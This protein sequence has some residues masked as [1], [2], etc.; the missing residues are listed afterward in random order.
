MADMRSAFRLWA[1]LA[2]VAVLVSALAGAQAPTRSAQ[3]RG[4]EAA[5]LTPA[6]ISG[7]RFRSIGPGIVSGRV[8]GL[9]VVPGKPSNYYVAA[10]SGGVWK[11][12]NDGATF[13]PVFDH[14]GSYSI[15]AITLDPNHPT[16]VWV[17]TGEN[18]AQRT[19][20]YGDGVYRSDDRGA[21]WRNMGLKDSRH[22]G[23]I[24]VDPRDSNTVYVAAEGPL[25]GAGGDRGVFKTTDG[26]AT[27]K[28]VL[29]I[30]EHTG[31][32][33]LVMDPRDPNTLYAS[34]YQRERHVYTLI[35]GGPESGIY[36]T[37]D[38]G[39]H[40]TRERRGLP[41]VSL[42]RIG[43]SISP[44]DPRIL[45]ATVEAAERQGGVFRST[46]GGASWEK[47]NP[48]QPGAMYYAQI[49]ADAKDPNRVFELDTTISVSDDGGA[50]FHELGEPNKH[51]DNHVI[52]I[53]PADSDHYLVGCDGGLYESWDRAASWEWK[54]NLPLGQYV[55]VAVDYAEPFY[56][57]YGGTQDNNDE[58][59]PSRTYS[60]NGLTSADWRI[61]H[62]G[63]GF[64]NAVDPTDPD[65]VYSE[66]QTGGISRVNLRTHEDISIQPQPAAGEDS[67]RWGWDAP[68]FISPFDHNRL[69]MAANKVFRSDDRGNT[70]K[71]V[72]GDL[73][74]AL[75]RDAL[76]VMGRIWGPDAVA[77]NS[78]T[79]PFGK[80]QDIAESPKQEGLL[81]AG[82]DD[83]LV[84]V[85][86][87]GGAHWTRYDKFPGVPDGTLVSRILPS[88]F[89]AHTVYVAFEN[90]KNDDFKP[91]LLKST[92]AGK[93]WT[94]IAANL[95]ANGPVL[96]LAQDDVDSNLLFVGTEFGLYVSNN[97]GASWIQMRDLP[98]IA[99]RDLQIQRREH[100]L[101]IGTFGRG[102]YVLD[103]Y[104]P[105][106]HLATAT[107][108]GPGQVLPMRP[109]LEYLQYDQYGAPGKADNGAAFF[110]AG[111]LG[112]VGL[113]NYWLG[114]VPRT[115]RQQMQESERAADR[116]GADFKPYP[117]PDELTAM[118]AQQPPAY[119]VVISDTNG[120]PVRVLAVPARAG[121]GRISWDLR[122]LATPEHRAGRGFGGGGGA[123]DLG[124]GRGGRGGA[125]APQAPPEGGGTPGGLVLPGR[126][127][128]T[129]YQHWQDKWTE[130][131][132]PQTLI[133]AA[134][135]HSTP[136]LAAL[137]A[138][139]DFMQKLEKL[140]NQ[141]SAVQ[142]YANQIS[143]DLTTLRSTAAAYP[144]QHQPLIDHTDAAEKQFAPIADALRGGFGFGGGRTGP[145]SLSSR[146]GNAAGA[147][148][149]SLSA[150]TQTS[151]DDVQIATAE[152]A[153][154]LPQLQKFGSTD[155]PALEREFT[156]AGAPI[157]ATLPAWPP[158]AGSPPPPL[159]LTP[160]R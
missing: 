2:G 144:D 74:R 7:L 112:P 36:K 72:S 76:P 10:A 80:M 139:A 94:S 156:A 85:T 13:T 3:G 157:P 9:A 16:T 38:G 121:L 62:G 153:K 19:V 54:T 105:L 77:K 87:D 22:I 135:P 12:V 142:A 56:N 11:T 127:Q 126:Y 1:R 23:R 122:T 113:I 49:T 124:G 146:L 51:V 96:A 68:F 27:W 125:G 143:A 136:P 37:T 110:T 64:H 20:S 155:L 98:T 152:L 50:T 52:W 86:L 45:Y 60:G 90:H 35:D 128:V 109:A 47:R 5:G 14:E 150:P 101:V 104:T 25:W 149:R 114:P 42:G 147:E 116:S 59:G 84:Q 118:N 53:D 65:I 117:T 131:G 103:D 99:V 75:D 31:A 18:N 138:H 61:T 57:I 134:D 66:S 160:H 93:T 26:G 106:R 141:L 71:E 55:D 95:P 111:N 82:T 81:W 24:I 17:G 115:D 83:G 119:S 48:I 159:K 78:S 8:V 133:V 108:T 30:S 158:A 28:N 107:I 44:A 34:A 79:A 92:D 4:G 58:G 32:S 29:A 148:S 88:R 123:A 89:D 154:W 41:A 6:S 140:Q 91:Y 100:D 120:K 33:D 63:D 151:L 39:A 130:L 145:P 40:W 43:L 46:D 73:T 102:I 70:W 67:F 129:L 69:Y 21:S 97:G 132:R 137:T 15:G